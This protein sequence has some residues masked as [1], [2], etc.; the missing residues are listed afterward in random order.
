MNKDMTLN[1]YQEHLKQ[2]SYYSD[3]M[4]DETITHKCFDCDDTFYQCDM[5]R[6]S[7]KGMTRPNWFCQ[8][9]FKSHEDE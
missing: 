5:T 2:S 4:E 6:F 9:C 8:A 3:E 1:E 7:F